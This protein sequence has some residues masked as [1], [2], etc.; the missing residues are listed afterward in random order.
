M[1]TDVDQELQRAKLRVEELRAQLS[2]HDY[3]YHVIDQPEISDGEYDE[4]MQELRS[5]EE[6]HPQ[7]IMPESLTQRVGG[8][9]VEAFGIVEHRVPLLSLANAFSEEELRAW[10]RRATGLTE[11][12]GFAM[13]C[14]PKIDG[15]AGALGYREGQFAGGPTRGG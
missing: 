4:L 13:V 2:Y 15:L 7:L 12:E 8:A 6:A 11:T 1:A 3:R 9:P 14:E 10:H 5:L